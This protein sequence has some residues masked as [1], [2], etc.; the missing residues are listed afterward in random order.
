MTPPTPLDGIGVNTEPKIERV[1]VIGCGVMGSGVT[2]VFAQ[3]GVDTTV[4]VSSPG[5]ERRGRA[6]LDRSLERGVQKQKFTDEERSAALARI[7][8]TTDLAELGDRQLIVE[9]INEDDVAKV[10]LFAKLSKVVRTPDAIVASTTSAIPIA[11]LA[12]VTERPGQ[13]VGMHFF[14]PAPVLPLVEVVPS[15]LTSAATTERVDRF[16][17]GVLGKQV[18][19]SPDRAGF[20][21]NA[22]LFPYLLSAIRM[23]DDGTAS[24]EVIDKAMVQGC[25]HPMGP[26]ALLDM[27]GLDTTAAIANAMYEEFKQPLYAAPPLLSRM[28]EAGLLG[29]KSGRGFY[30]YQ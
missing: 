29:K 17:T 15:V 8:F 6:R 30:D 3:A 14:N 25:A 21:V 20:I 4:L 5:S 19:H 28:V 22:L 12:R 16:V 23:V 18:V 27:I 2:E 1:A 10:A 24:A 11:R 26:L 7:R 9:A 13:V